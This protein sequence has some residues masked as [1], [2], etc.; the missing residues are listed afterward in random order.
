MTNNSGAGG[1]SGVDGRAADGR[2]ADGPG[3]DGRGSQEHTCI[4]SVTLSDQGENPEELLLGPLIEELETALHDV[5]AGEL[6]HE[7]FDGEF[8]HL[9][10]LGSDAD[11]LQELI[12]GVLNS[13]PLAKEA[14][15]TK[16]YGTLD[17]PEAEEV[18][19]EY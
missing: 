3:A 11:E 7:D 5:E 9:T 19:L 4:L 15:L 1:E 12:E 13:S 2:A 14:R 17:D 8:H 18:E 10:F 16:R 6:D